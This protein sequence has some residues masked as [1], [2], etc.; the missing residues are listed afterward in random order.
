MGTFVL[1]D[2]QD[3]EV[4]IAADQWERIDAAC[5]ISKR[6]TISACAHCPCA[7]FTVRMVEECLASMR[8]VVDGAAEILGLVDEASSAHLYLTVRPN[9]CRHPGWRDPGHAE[10]VDAVGHVTLRPR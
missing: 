7:V 10:W 3:R 5:E 2:G 4:A 8:G 6:S 1:S 9:R